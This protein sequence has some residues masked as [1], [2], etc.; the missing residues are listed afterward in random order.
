MAYSHQ[1]LVAIT[2]ISTIEDPDQVPAD[3]LVAA[4]LERT[5]DIILHDR[6]AAFQ[7]Q[8]TTVISEKRS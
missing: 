6:E 3:H 4:L 2:V 7:I 1:Y 5:R 8:D